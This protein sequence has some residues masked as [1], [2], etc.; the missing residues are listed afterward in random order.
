MKSCFSFVLAVPQVGGYGG[1]SDTAPSC[2]PGDITASCDMI[3]DLFDKLLDNLATRSCSSSH[4]I[5]NIVNLW[6]SLGLDLMEE[7]RD[8]S[9]Q[10]VVPLIIL[11]PSAISS[12]LR[13][14]LNCGTNISLKC[15][16]SVLYLLK[17]CN[18]SS[19]LNGTNV[20]L[21]EDA[22]F[23]PVLV[24]FLT[25]NFGVDSEHKCSGFVGSYIASLFHNL[26]VRLTFACDCFVA[27]S[28]R[29]NKLKV[30]L[31][32]VVA[33][34]LRVGDNNGPLDAQCILMRHLT[35]LHYAGLEEINLLLE[36]VNKTAVVI[37]KHLLHKSHAAKMHVSTNGSSSY[38]S[39]RY[40]ATA[41]N[42]VSCGNLGGGSSLMGSQSGDGEGVWGGLSH[43]PHHSSMPR[44][45]TETFLY[46]LLTLVEILLETPLGGQVRVM[47]LGQ[48][49]QRPIRP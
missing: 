24:L 4:E 48:F 19:N 41:N 26:L 1:S 35:K 17:L 46:T 6:L 31:L 32:E 11:P 18:N 42:V 22:N 23:V 40:A 36:I 29:G 30:L 20:H 7:S 8:K 15:W 37:H 14:L 5:E 44:P 47:V 10:R 38:G 34:L 9:N 27:V 49:A 43:G 13:S 16:G 33:R 28:E 12:L 45:K 21:V 2:G 3:I 25:T 39:S